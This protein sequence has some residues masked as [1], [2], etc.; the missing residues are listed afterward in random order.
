[1]LRFVPLL[2]PFFGIGWWWLG[3]PPGWGWIIVPIFPPMPISFGDLVVFALVLI[4]IGWGL[5]FAI[6]NL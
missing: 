5:R 1:M 4:G 3:F 6:E 2:I